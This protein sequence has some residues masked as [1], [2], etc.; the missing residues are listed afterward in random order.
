[1]TR[2]RKIALHFHSA[3]SITLGVEPFGRRRCLN[4]SG[5]N[6]RT[7]LQAFLAERNTGAIAIRDANPEANLNAQLFQRTSGRFDS[8]GSNGAS[9]RGPA[10]IRM[11]RAQRG[12]MD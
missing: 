7:R 12:S 8:E 9:S 1:M 6:D 5:P 10:S 2:H 3:G 4:A 11:I